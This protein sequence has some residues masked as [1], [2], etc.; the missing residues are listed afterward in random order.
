MELDSKRHIISSENKV[1]GG[2]TVYPCFER[3]HCRAVLRCNVVNHSTNVKCVI[4]V[5]TGTAFPQ[6][7]VANRNPICGK[8]ALNQFALSLKDKSGDILFFFLWSTDQPHEK[9]K[10]ELVVLTVITCKAKSYVSELH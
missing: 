5:N 6:E 3:G 7:A 9:T 1:W 4:K 10:T 8:P 2:L